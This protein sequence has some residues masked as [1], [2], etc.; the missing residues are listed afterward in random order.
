MPNSPRIK[1]Y[2]FELNPS[3]YTT[4]LTH[5]PALKC[6]FPDNLYSRLVREYAG[7]VTPTRRFDNSLSLDPK[8]RTLERIKSSTILIARR[9]INQTPPPLTESL[10]HYAKKTQFPHR[11]LTVA[12]VNSLTRKNPKVPIEENPCLCGGGRTEDRVA[13][14]CFRYR[15]CVLFHLGSYGI[16]PCV[17]VCVCV[18]YFRALVSEFLA[19]PLFSLLSFLAATQMPRTCANPKLSSRLAIVSGRMFS[20]HLRETT[21][22]LRISLPGTTTLP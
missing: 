19:P 12:Q 2:D 5:Q 22:N 9:L 6:D 18:S 4:L 14:N 15:K 3:Y 13:Y 21:F 16:T 20:A 10:L 1:R 7:L 17:C 8:K 11:S